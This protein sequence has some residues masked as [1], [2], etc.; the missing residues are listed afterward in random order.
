MFSKN[1][2]KSYDHLESFINTLS[3]SLAE[4]FY[5]LLLYVYKLGSISHKYIDSIY[6]LFN[7]KLLKKT[8][9][10]FIRPFS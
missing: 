4:K 10:P 7:V 5:L 6:E 8:V 3:H 1:Y 2:Q 9:P